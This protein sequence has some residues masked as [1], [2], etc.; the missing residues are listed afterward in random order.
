MTSTVGFYVRIDIDD[1][2]SS[3]V[4][5]DAVSVAHDAFDTA[6]TFVDLYTSLRTP[7]SATVDERLTAALQER[8]DLLSRAPRVLLRW[9]WIIGPDEPS[10]GD[11]IDTWLERLTSRDGGESV[12][13]PSI[14][15]GV[16]QHR[17]GNSPIVRWSQMMPPT[18]TV[19][20]EQAR[21][22]ELHALLLRSNA[23]W[24]PTNYHYRLPSGEHTDVFVRMADAIQTPQ[25]AYAVSTWLADRLRPGTSV[26]VD[27]GGLTS[28]LIQLESFMTKF[29]LHVGPTVILS[30]Y[31]VG[32]SAV[33]QAVENAASELSTHVLGIV[34]VS[35]SGT[36]LRT[37][38][39]ELERL[40]SYSGL[41]VT[42]DL[43]VDRT[44]GYEPVDSVSPKSTYQLVAQIT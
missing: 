33:R 9:P 12:I 17:V 15:T 20:L 6:L 5:T 16:I 28:L 23:I 44:Y 38:A 34:S 35:S 7:P 42:L 22:L 43:L 37:L 32:R 3:E 1:I 8:L 25:D 24:E 36:V 40:S 27:T 26:V 4:D 10:H 19:I 29:G 30:E 41:D 2:V 21:A 39:D 14:S 31:P 13:A 18:E 11:R